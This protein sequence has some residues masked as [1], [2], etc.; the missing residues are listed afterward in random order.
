MSIVLMALA[1]LA[2]V[3]MPVFAQDAAQRMSGPA[4]EA[5]VFSALQPKP[6]LSQFTNALRESDMDSVLRSGGQY[7]IF[8]PTNDA[9]GR[10]PANKASTMNQNKQGIDYVLGYHIVGGKILPQQL[11][12]TD[13]LTTLSTMDV[14]VSMGGNDIYIDGA[15]ISG[16]GIDTGNVMIYPISAVMVP[17]R[18]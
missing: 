4:S 13:S 17:P 9:F 16:D 5:A 12:Y 8:A 14:P 11:K 18:M 10:M 15:R 2:S 6:E 3:A 1:V 7:T